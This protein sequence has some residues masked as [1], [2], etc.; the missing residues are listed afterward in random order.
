[1]HD[2]DDLFFTPTAPLASPDDAYLHQ[3]AGSPGP[4]FAHSLEWRW[5]NDIFTEVPGECWARPRVNL[6][7]GETMSPLQ[8]LFAVA[9]IANGVGSRLPRTDWLYLNTDIAVHIH[10]IPEGEW[11]G[12]RA[13]THYSRDGVGISQGTLFDEHGAVAFIQQAQLVRRR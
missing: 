7:S 6:V 10:R 11:I 13:E 4:R 3:P 9:D 8:R 5:L 12:V 1:V 2:T